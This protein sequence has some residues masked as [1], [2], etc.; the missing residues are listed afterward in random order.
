M[1]VRITPERLVAPGRRGLGLGPPFTPGRGRGY[2]HAQDIV[3]SPAEQV[4]GR[5]EELG[6]IDRALDDLSLGTPGIVELVG[7]PGIG[8]TRLLA[9]L[10]ARADAEGTLVLSGR[11]AEFERD[12]PFWVF[13]DA[14]DEYV[15]GLE[16]GRIDALSDDVRAE[17][18][19]VLPSLTLP[20]AASGTTLRDERYRTH[21]A[22][23]ELLEEL[24]RTRPLVLMLDDLHWAD[25][26]SIELVG[27]LLRR[28]P[29]AA[30][31]IVISLRP[32]Q[33]SERLAAALEQAERGG[34]LIRLELG[35][36]SAADAR[37][38]LGDEIRAEV[39]DALYE[40]SGGNPFYLEQLA[41]PR[42]AGRQGSG[43]GGDI[44]LGGVSVPSAVIAALAEELALLSD[45][46]R[47]VLEG[48]AVAGD[49]FD[50]ELTAATAGVSEDRAL[51]ALDGLLRLDIIRPTD[52][53]RRFRFR[54]PLVRRA[55]Y[56]ATPGAWRLAAHGRSAAA[57]HA[58]GAPAAA[59]AHHVEQA[60]RLGDETAIAV[61]REAGEATAQRAPESAGRWF[62]A[63][64]RLTPESAPAKDRIALHAALAGS[65]AATGH[66]AEAHAAL[67]EAL[68]LLPG[69]STLV[70][71]RLTAAC[72]GV[73]Q[74]LGRHEAAHARLLGAL[75]ALGDPVSDQAVELE[76]SLALNGFF[77]QDYDDA[78]R[79]SE[80]ALGAARPLGDGAL[81]AA[82]AGVAALS[83][84]FA[85]A[86]AE[87]AHHATEAAT[88]VDAMSDA[89]LAAR[90]DAAAFL[91]AGELYLD[92][93]E[94]AID[95]ANRALAIARATGQ[96]ELLPI[97]IPTLT[98]ALAARGRLPEAADLLDAAIE[99][100]RVAGNRQG[101]AWNLLNRCYVATMT[102]EVDLATA[103]G[104]ESMYLTRDLDASHVSTYAGVCRAMAHLATGDADRATA[105]FVASGG[106]D[107]LR[108]IPGGWRG[109]FLEMLTRSLLMLGRR[110]EAESAA[111]CAEA[112]AATT[113]LPMA[114]AWAHRA[115]AAVA[116]DA[117]DA[118]G[119]LARA[120]DSAAL[121]AE[122]GAP[123]EAAISRTLAGHALAAAG[124]RDEA[125]ELL[126]R[127]A[128]ELE[129]C[130]ALRYRDEAEREL[131]RL[132]HRIH[133]RSAP[134]GQDAVGVASLSARE[135]QVARLLV[136]RRT[137]PEIAAEL[138][139]SQKTVEAHIRNM[140]RKLDVS[141]RTG[142]ARAMERADGV[143]PTP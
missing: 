11:A 101:L 127:A 25:S 93:Y 6:V 16:P 135:L 21:R 9:E 64:L 103:A 133:R 85:G 141:S 121:A 24:A 27:A 20:A 1:T 10:A 96:G 50:P 111:G 124:R 62:A 102:G 7:E 38:F 126:K 125:L 56:E 43:G 92:R 49:P 74:L 66:F 46:V 73:E 17:L 136:D 55:V 47:R 83:C 67:L 120:L 61:L 108:L 88:I 122:A 4:V 70:R 114:T 5:A 34:S 75:D 14:L 112:V 86:A 54:H 132:G 32:R 116:L 22:M 13:V 105:Q 52:V 142:I 57:L 58:R 131:R 129:A 113:A 106:G 140:F 95:H 110:A 79:W 33:V 107:D 23:R 37:A 77:R 130:G 80:R 139:L 44:H 35:S 81:V 28:P 40:E 51:E 99:G 45:D 119:A 138:Y 29:G 26:G 87:G 8:K 104:E 94:R 41:R 76:I 128:A 60:G 100:T 65:H 84:A 123:V 2:G 59:R 19:Q 36:L 3:G 91:S 78:Q 143:D 18:A 98:V 117:G 42:S 12:L 134:A 63:A 69:D 109:H 90:L 53:P 71:V 15:Q 115:T 30:V 82:A 68:G 48:A 31:L 137:N 39:V 89:E 72:A 97:L 118:M